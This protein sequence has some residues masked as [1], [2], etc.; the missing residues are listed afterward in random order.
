MNPEEIQGLLV[1]L[2]GDGTSFLRMLDQAASQTVSVTA[3][4][5]GAGKRIEGIAT[6][7]KEFGNATVQALGALGAQKFLNNAMSMFAET[8]TVQIRLKASLK[9]TAEEI[10]TLYDAYEKYAGTLRNATGASKDDTFALLQHV[11][12]Q[13]I[14]GKQAMDLVTQVNALAAATGRD[15]HSILRGIEMLEKGETSMIKRLLNLRDIKDNEELVANINEKVNKGLKIQGDLMNSTN[16]I[17][18]QYSGAWKGLVKQFGETVSQAITPMAKGMTMLIRQF[19]NLDDATR[20]MIVSGAMLAAGLL[21]ISPLLTTIMKFVTPWVNY[22][23]SGFGLIGMALTAV[24]Y[25]LMELVKKFVNWG[26]VVTVTKNVVLLGF[27]AIQEAANFAVQIVSDNIGWLWEGLQQGTSMIGQTFM[28]VGQI[29]QEFSGYVA[30]AATAVTASVMAYYGLSAAIAI[31]STLYTAL[32]LNYVVNTALVLAWKGAV[33]VATVATT[34]FNGVHALLS[35]TMSLSSIAMG[36]YTA[37]TGVATG[38]T[39]LLTSAVLALEA[40]LA[41]ITLLA[42]AV[43]AI[44]LAAILAGIAITVAGLASGF[45]AVAVSAG[46]F[47]TQVVNGAA[48]AVGQLEGFNTV[49]NDLSNSF[50]MLMRAMKLGNGMDLAWKIMMA[51]FKLTYE[52]IKVMMPPLWQF[53]KTGFMTIWDEIGDALWRSLLSGIIHF[54][55]T[56]L[57]YMDPTGILSGWFSSMTKEVDK[58]QGELASKSIEKIKDSLAEAVKI[59]NEA[60]AQADQSGIKEARKNIQEL[61]SQLKTME[62]Q[63]KNKAA[64]DAKKLDPFAP[65]AMGAK[66]AKE[67][68]QKLE[69]VLAGS[70][71]AAVFAYNYFAGLKDRIPVGRG[72]AAA[73]E[74]G[75]SGGAGSHGNTPVAGTPAA[76]SDAKMALDIQ[77]NEYLKTI[78]EAVTKKSETAMAGI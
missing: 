35:G 33:L 38:A 78:A 74:G 40:A 51:Q 34:V 77:R 45:Y 46:G 28:R 72:M 63:A 11:A 31:T 56:M 48:A 9:G 50:G 2:T 17:L 22:F 44:V 58:L 52:Q 47:F 55:E 25:V 4:I 30:L 6:S 43:T 65:I 42:F 66:A 67:E 76:S 62:E 20:K 73:S 41:P 12:A 18:K 61:E 16:G 59:Y 21:S 24:G 5:E 29:L 23:V 37:A 14:Q 7:V 10:N 39:N 15:T 13:G 69:G 70:Q 36:I 64:G 60:V 71:Q 32:G 68:I 54:E 49:V 1:R 75:G 3:A 57:K 53:L 27:K 19:L 8:E 26:E